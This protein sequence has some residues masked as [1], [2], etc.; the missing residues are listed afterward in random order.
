MHRLVAETFIPN[1]E[2]KPQVN[3]KWGIKTDN[4]ASELEWNTQSENMQ[5]ALKHKLR[6]TKPILQYSKNNELIKVWD[7]IRQAG[8]EIGIPNQSIVRCA[9]GKRKSAG[10]YIWRYKDTQ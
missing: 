1:P 10:G 5:H 7:C 3:H 2:N 6:H 8:R 9:K 4:R